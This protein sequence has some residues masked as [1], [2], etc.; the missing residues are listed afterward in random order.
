MP[1]TSATCVPMLRVGDVAAAGELIAL[2]AVLASAL[3]VALAGDGGVAAAGPP[4]AAGGEDHVDRTEDVLYAVAVVLDAARVQ[5]KAAPRRAPPLRRLPDRAL[6]DARH[7]RRAPRRPVADVL[8]DLVET[9]GVFRDEIVIEPVVLD[10]QV[11]DAVE[12]GDVAARLDG[13]EQIAGAG[14]RRDA[15]I[16][17]DDTGAVLA[18]LPDVVRRDGGALGDVGAADPHD[19]GGQDVGPRI[20]GAVDAEG[21]LVGRRGADH[22]QPAVVVDVRRLQAHAGELAHQVRFLVGQA[23]P[24]EHGEGVGAVR[25]LNVAGWRRR[26]ARW[27]RRRGW[28]ESLPART[29]RGGR[30]AAGGRGASLA[31]SA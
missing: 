4:D 29:D 7:F 17:D 30:R 8:G 27:P 28:S 21:E 14:D 1:Q 13:Q 12:Q 26:R 23:R 24:A 10:H 2:L 31:G 20:G 22:A 15:R 18:G 25:R 16:D 19:L 9:D 6:G 5:Q 11:E 3:A